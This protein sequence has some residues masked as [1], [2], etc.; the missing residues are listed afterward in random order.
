M[1]YQIPTIKTQREKSLAPEQ[2][3]QIIDA[4]RD[5]KYS[6]ACVLLLRFIGHNPQYYIPY[7]TYNRLRK[8]NPLPE[9]NPSLKTVDEDRSNPGRCPSTRKASCKIVDLN[10]LQVVEEK[11][12]S[13][14]GGC[15]RQDSVES[16]PEDSITDSATPGDSWFSGVSSLFDC[17]TG[18]N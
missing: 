10:H 17:C 1:T 5:G 8:E 9:S 6:W 16:E 2:V 3:E 15:Q 14:Q 18:L 13:V 7:R 12:V 4:I 11:T